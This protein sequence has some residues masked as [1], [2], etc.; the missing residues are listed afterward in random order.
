M[1][2]TRM[3]LMRLM[4]TTE[5]GRLEIPPPP[6]YRLSLCII[7]QSQ[8]PGLDGSMAA[9]EPRWLSIGWGFPAGGLDVAAR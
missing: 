4:T 3:A 5:S 8:S 9:G 6:K 7:H 1:T 2:L